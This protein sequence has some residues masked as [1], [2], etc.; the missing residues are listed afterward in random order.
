MI[1]FLIAVDIRSPSGII[2]TMFAHDLY[3]D[4]KNLAREDLI[5]M[6]DTVMFTYKRPK[7]NKDDYH[8]QVNP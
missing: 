5:K 6:I 2:L 1:Q 4:I 8:V 3:D 7:Y